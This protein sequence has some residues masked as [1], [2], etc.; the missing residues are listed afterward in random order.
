MVNS[1]CKTT[2]VLLCSAVLL[3]GVGCSRQHEEQKAEKTDITVVTTANGKIQGTAVDDV[4]V[5]KGVPF[6]KP[7]VDELRFAPPEKPEAWDDIMEC[8]EFKEI[9]AQ[10]RG[11]GVN[12]GED[13]LYLNVWAPKKSL[14]EPPKE[15]LPVLVFIHGGAFAVGSTSDPMYDGTA[16]AKDG[17]ICVTAA[18]RLNMAGFLAS[19]VLEK[20]YG[21]LGNLGLLDQ[22]ESLKWVKDNI[23][24]FGGD[25]NNITI[26]GESAGAMSM[27]ALTIS[28]LSKGLF[29][30][31]I[32]ESGSVFTQAIVD[33]KSHGGDAGQ[34]IAR[35]AAL[36]ETLGAS[37]LKELRAL[38]IN[39]MVEKSAFSMDLTNQNP[40]CLMPVYDGK[41]IPEDPYSSIKKGDMHEVSVLTGYNTD[42]GTSFVPEGITEET[43]IDFVTDI[44][45]EQSGQVLERFPVD[46]NHSATDRARGL[47]KM[48][49]QIG[50]QIY[51]DELAAL[52][53]DAYV[54]NFDYHVPQYDQSGMGVMHGLELPFVFDTFADDMVLPEDGEA[55][56]EQIHD[57][58]VSFI[59]TGNPNSKENQSPKW[60]K[61]NAG[62][63][64]ILRINSNSQ[65]ISMEDQ[66]E[67][68]FLTELLF[69]K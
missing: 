15:K 35:G 52:G 5:F 56:T 29:Q 14:E 21:Y 65:S 8:K 40:L 28:P 2:L 10:T 42:E 68:E 17:V 49:F 23:Q 39:A 36:M 66:E 19:E 37:D 27:S 59:K 53:K 43:Y 41:I 24:N 60:P 16:F 11:N 30:K 22:I 25:S 64:E 33:P 20:E 61:Y 47:V 48:S 54:Y 4:V 46:D 9:S 50:C 44:F 3:A 51:G 67:L 12:G 32:M 38:D 34:S 13:C 55:V 62:E 7:P 57:Y 58:W 1:K 6:A 69:N 18:Y 63:K 26:S 45:G 31:A